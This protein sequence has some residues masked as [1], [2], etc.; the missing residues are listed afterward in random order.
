M[1]DN[2]PNYL[3][4]HNIDPARIEPAHIDNPP[5]FDS[6]RSDRKQAPWQTEMTLETAIEILQFVEGD[7]YERIAIRK[8]IEAL[9]NP[10]VKTSDR[11]PA[12]AD[13]G[14]DEE[15]VTIYDD[16]DTRMMGVDYWKCVALV[17]GRFPYWLPVPKL[18]EVEE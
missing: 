2:Y 14:V 13:A 11:L 10:W 17:P 16:G 1:K 6:I 3:N 4:L 15:I 9:S 18:P 12:E 5:G 8:V 7:I